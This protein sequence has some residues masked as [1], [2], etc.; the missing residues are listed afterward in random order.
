MIQTETRCNVNFFS[1]IGG[2][3]EII[4]ELRD[5]FF[6]KIGYQTI[7]YHI[8]NDTRTNIT[9]CYYLNYGLEKYKHGTYL[10]YTYNNKGSFISIHNGSIDKLKGIDYENFRNKHIDRKKIILQYK[11][12][13][14]SMNLSVLDSVYHYSDA[15]VRKNINLFHIMNIVDIKCDAVKIIKFFP[16]ETETVSALDINLEHIYKQEKID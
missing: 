2:A 3:V 5:K 10:V 4:S 12:S 7:I 9:L 6:D 16:F 8:E 13:P 14:I 15:F 11:E 1:L